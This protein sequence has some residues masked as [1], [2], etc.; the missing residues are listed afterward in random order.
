L[1]TN[2]PHAQKA[3]EAASKRRASVVEAA[4]EAVAVTVVVVAEVVA[5]A[6]AVADTTATVV[7]TAAAA[8]DTTGINLHN[9]NQTY[10]SPAPIIR[11]RTFFY[12]GFRGLGYDL[13]SRISRIGV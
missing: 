10:S 4:A 2:L 9:Q 7:A 12:R 6:A 8:A 13:L 11:N 3:K 5:E 1:L